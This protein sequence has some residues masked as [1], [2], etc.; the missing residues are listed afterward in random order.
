MQLHPW[1]KMF[2]FLEKSSTA[3]STD[4]QLIDPRPQ[5]HEHDHDQDP[6]PHQNIQES[7]KLSPGFEILISQ[8]PLPR[9]QVRE[10]HL[11]NG[12]NGVGCFQLILACDN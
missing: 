3:L 11:E 6:D 10:L 5:Y 2:V 1:Q 4:P 8:C 12:E 7:V 9:L